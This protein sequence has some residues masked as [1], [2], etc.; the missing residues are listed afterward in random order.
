MRFLALLASGSPSAKSGRETQHLGGGPH[1]FSLITPR[2]G[3]VVGSEGPWVAQSLLTNEADPS[4]AAVIDL[5][6]LSEKGKL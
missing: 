5:S 4:A 2:G 6:R 1:A 3:W